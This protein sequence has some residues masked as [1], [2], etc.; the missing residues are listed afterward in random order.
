MQLPTP[1][2]HNNV[3]LS[4]FESMLKTNNILFFDADQFEEIIN[5]YLENG[6]IAL[7]KKATKLGLQQHPSS[8]TLKLFQVEMF[9]F[10]N[11][12][13]IADI[14]LDELYQLEQSNEEIYIQKAN[15]LSRRDKHKHASVLLEKALEITVDQA[16]VLS[17]IGMEY[18]FLEDYE[19]AKNNFIRCLNDQKDEIH[20][21]Y[22]ALYNVIYC[23]EYLEQTQEAINYLNVF[24]NNN[25]YSEVAWHQIGKQYSILKQYK[26]ALAS[27]DFAII[28]DDRFIGAYLEKGKVLEKMKRY[29]E[30]IESFIITL[31]LDDPTS[32]ALL[33]IGKCY[34]KIKNDDTSTACEHI[35]RIY[36]SDAPR[37][38]GVPHRN[39]RKTNENHVL[40]LMLFRFSGVMETNGTQWNSGL[41]EPLE[42]AGRKSGQSRKL[43]MRS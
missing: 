34:E 21:D 38:P 10:E 16:D 8:T 30:A 14:L 32:F 26:K 27:F 1:D 31:G 20:T 4:K 25:P 41:R 29:E 23:F 6:K 39:A 13:D 3:S 24:L 36:S 5:H 18:L 42:L 43:S 35:R 9:I 15:I 40:V 17:L 19:N 37:G 22:S 12:L 28:S 2:E 33:R 11:E 7:A